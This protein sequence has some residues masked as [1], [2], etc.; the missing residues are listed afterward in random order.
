M[1]SLD[2]ATFFETYVRPRRDARR[3][4][5]RMVLV[6]FAIVSPTLVMLLR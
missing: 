5:T 4:A 3:F 2:Y 6:T 1:A